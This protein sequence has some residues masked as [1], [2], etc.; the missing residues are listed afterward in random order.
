MPSNWNSSM[1]HDFSRCSQPAP[2]NAEKCPTDRATRWSTRSGAERGEHPG[3]RR[4][5]VVAD[6]MGPLDA[7]LSSTPSTSPTWRQGVRLDLGG[8]I[9][10]AEATQVGGDAAVAGRGQ[11][12]DLVA[13]ES[14]RVGP[15]VEQQHRR[16]VLHCD[17]EPDPVH[18]ERIT[19]PSSTSAR[20]SGRAPPGPARAAQDPVATRSTAATMRSAAGDIGT[21]RRALDR[22]LIAAAQQFGVV[23]RGGHQR[24]TE[25]PG[26]VRGHVLDPG[27]LG[28]DLRQPMAIEVSVSGTNGSTRRAS[29]VAT[30]GRARW[31]RQCHRRG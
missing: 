23:R 14:V 15:A 5:P 21:P 1:Y 17:L 16:P 7:E 31:R 8:A 6:H 19:P 24:P 3:E 28:L 20:R 26:R 29:P 9:G 18:L 11:G 10:R 30:D 22:C 4:T 2:R 27:D 25:V 12:V 13:P